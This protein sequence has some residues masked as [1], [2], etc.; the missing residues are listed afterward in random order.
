MDYNVLQFSD[1]DAVTLGGGTGSTKVSGLNELIQVVLIELLSDP[2]P[3][4]ARGAGMA[5]LLLE[6]NPTESAQMP[7]R[8]Q[9][10]VAT[11]KAH[12]LANQTATNG[13]KQE[14]LSDLKLVSASQDGT[15]WRVNIQITNQAGDTATVSPTL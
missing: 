8:L 10:S 9:Q 15:L 1:G 6:S 4:K 3:G 5:T 11:A 14:R 7:A 2:L 12:V 13:T